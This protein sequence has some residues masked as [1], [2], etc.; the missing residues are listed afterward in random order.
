MTSGL[1][2]VRATGEATRNMTPAEGIMADA[3]RAAADNPLGG[4][5]FTE[6]QLADGGVEYRLAY[7]PASL[8][9]LRGLYQAL[10]DHVHPDPPATD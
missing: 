7:Q 9:M 8:A 4:V 10:G 6:H 3:A 5:L 2:V 1:R